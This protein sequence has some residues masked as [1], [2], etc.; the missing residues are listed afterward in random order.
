MNDSD[1]DHKKGEL[2]APFF[3]APP[4]KM[5][6]FIT[7]RCLEVYLNQQEKH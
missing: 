1:I 7:E 2:L 4:K 3:Y 5:Y 6:C